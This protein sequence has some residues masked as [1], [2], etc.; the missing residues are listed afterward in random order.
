MS[1]VADILQALE[2]EIVDVR[3]RR[4]AGQ[5]CAAS[6]LSKVLAERGA[7]NLVFTLRT[8]TESDGNGRA[9]TAPMIWAVS[10]VIVAHPAW[11]D[12]GSEWLEAFD[13]I[14]L[15]SLERKAR[16]HR[17]AVPKRAAIAAWLC[18]ALS[19]IFRPST[20]DQPAARRKR[21]RGL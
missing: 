5:T 10:D 6:T 20:N 2:I 11:A 17:S 12:R 15:E 7:G 21:E 14:D 18:A 4:R 8:I 19:E 3:V 13:G 9:L 1:D 16:Q